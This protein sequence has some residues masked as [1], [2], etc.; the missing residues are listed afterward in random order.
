MKSFAV[1][2]LSY[3]LAA[4][5]GFAVF[6]LTAQ[7]GFIFRVFIAD[8]A[9]TVLIFLIGTL[10]GNASVYDPYWSVAPIVIISASFMFQG[11]LRLEALPLLGAIWFW[12][13]RLTANWAYTFS[14]LHRQDWRYDLLK[15]KSS[16]WFP[17]VNFLGIHLFPTLIVFSVMVPALVYLEDPA[18]RTM[19]IPA[20]LI[21]YA[22]AALQMVSDFQMHRFRKSA[23]RTEIIHIGLWEHSRHPNYL[24]EILMWWGVYLVMLS[25]LPQYVYLAVGPLAN[26]L[27]FLFI[28]IPMAE[29]RLA[30]NKSDFERYYNE[31]RVLLPIPKRKKTG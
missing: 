18:I 3:L 25:V 19:T 24:G 6:F 5:V 17:L 13:V 14:G 21:C 11:T 29:K 30:A 22:A 28:S 23:D 2:T 20:L 27:M 31:T 8:V 9:A 10:L 16:A 7:F 26:T 12:G 15:D 4:A 1:I